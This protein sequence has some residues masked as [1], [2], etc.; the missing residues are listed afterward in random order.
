MT[1]KNA[2]R[3]EINDV[4]GIAGRLSY[5]EFFCWNRVV[6]QLEIQTARPGDRLKMRER[7]ETGNA[8]ES[9]R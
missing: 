3:T 7:P 1:R 2:Q 4:F 8:A 5:L 6:G 9:V